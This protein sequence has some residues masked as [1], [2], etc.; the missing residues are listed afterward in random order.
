MSPI[1]VQKPT[2][3]G[4]GLNEHV[5]GYI[6]K[7][8][9]RVVTP[10]FLGNAVQKVEFRPPSL[11]GVMRFWH[12]AQGPHCLKTEGEVF[13]S[14]GK[15][16]SGQA[17]FFLRVGQS[18]VR[19][20]KLE[21]W[22]APHRYLA[23]GIGGS[24]CIPPG[25]TLT[26]TLVFR[27]TAT[28]KTR[29]DVLRSLRFLNYFGGLGA[30]SRRGFGSVVLLD[31]LPADYDDLVAQLQR[32][33][34]QL[35]LVDADEASYTMFSRGARIVVLP[36]GNTWAEA[37]ERIG[38]LMSSVRD[39]AHSPP[40]YPW[41]RQDAQLMA[42]FLRTGEASHAP[43][44]AAFGLPHNYYF[45]QSGTRV[46]VRG[47]QQTTRRASPLFIH[48]H[49]MRDRQHA[50]VVTFLPAPLLPPEGRIVLRGRV[51][52]RVPPPDHWGAIEDFLDHLAAEPGA[53]E[54]SI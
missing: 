37:L 10:L 23:Y 51:T 36:A 44:R 43:A 7:I 9:L 11:K 30:R 41:A 49:Q 13:G 4:P 5:H 39:P 38:S 26:F 54:V 34:A 42:G 16:K 2:I 12:R 27:P 17:A 52:T 22:S 33:V 8:D 29:E 6:Q 50:L 47:D 21:G 32:E 1:R 19:T 35:P 3:G 24:E 15:S 46:Y 14:S 18:A 45:R 25:E 20:G 48:V 53:K 31:D 40:G 28:P